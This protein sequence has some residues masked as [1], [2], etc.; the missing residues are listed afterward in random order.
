MVKEEEARNEQIESQ[1]VPVAQAEEAIELKEHADRQHQR[2]VEPGRGVRQVEVEEHHDP[3]LSPRR[4][5]D[6]RRKRREI[7]RGYFSAAIAN[8]VARSICSCQSRS[9]GLKGKVM[10]RELLMIAPSPSARIALTT[11]AALPPWAP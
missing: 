9:L 1:D 6:A 4:S 11:S 8:R 7:W 2:Q 10:L 3:A 5:S